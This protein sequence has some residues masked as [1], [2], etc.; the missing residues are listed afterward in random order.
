MIRSHRVTVLTVVLASEGIS[1]QN[2]NTEKELMVLT[3]AGLGELGLASRLTSHTVP[4]VFPSRI[5]TY[6]A[7]RA[8]TDVAFNANAARSGKTK[9]DEMPSR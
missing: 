1:P 5:T 2:M 4:P 3:E 7:H 6:N 9:R 8:G